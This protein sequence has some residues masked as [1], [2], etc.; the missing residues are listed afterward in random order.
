MCKE[1][2]NDARNLVENHWNVIEAHLES[3]VAGEKPLKFEGKSYWLLEEPGQLIIRSLNGH[4]KYTHKF[5]EETT[6]TNTNETSTGKLIAADMAVKLGDKNHTITNCEYLQRIE[7][8]EPNDAL[9]VCRTERPGNFI[10]LTAN[11]NISA[12]EYV[13]EKSD[14]ETITN[15]VKKIGDELISD[16]CVFAIGRLD[17]G[18]RQY[19]FEMAGG[20][21]ICL[22]DSSKGEWKE[23]A[24]L[25]LSGGIDNAVWAARACS[26]IHDNTAPEEQGATI[27][28]MQV[29]KKALFPETAV[30]GGTALEIEGMDNEV[31]VGYT[32]GLRD[33]YVQIQTATDSVRCHTVT[34]QVAFEILSSLD[35]GLVMNSRNRIIVAF[36]HK[37]RPY[38]IEIIGG[39][40]IRLID[41]YDCPTLVAVRNVHYAGDDWDINHNVEIYDNR[42]CDSEAESKEPKM[43]N[44][45]KNTATGPEA[46]TKTQDNAFQELFTPAEDNSKVESESKWSLGKKFLVGAAVVG[47]VM[48]V[49]Y[50]A[51]KLLNN[52]T[53]EIL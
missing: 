47:T 25:E 49:G 52:V 27:T 18:D 15:M 41:M 24:M 21:Y 31:V 39:S 1:F 22:I 44:D 14:L 7:G 38:A 29:Y 6:M 37:R 16:K 36:K 42:K 28:G 50:G 17:R 48:A 20:D 2:D 40:N 46:E 35:D 4:K 13:V 51:C 33:K 19:M 53:D 26:I 32:L 12:V 34:L 45:E 5:K 10:P 43:E 8:V 23:V 3:G 30:V 9:V 11:N